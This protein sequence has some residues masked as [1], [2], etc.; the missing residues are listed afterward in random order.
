MTVYT[1]VEN[2][3]KNGI[4]VKDMRQRTG[5]SMTEINKS[6]KLLTARQLITAHHI[7]GDQTKNRR[8]FVLFDVEPGKDASSGP[9]Y[10]GGEF[11]EPFLDFLLDAVLKI[12]AKAV[13]TQ[14][15][16][17]PRDSVSV[18]SVSSSESHERLN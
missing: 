10:Q 14:H 4:W 12:V 8:M 18:L 3:K 16:L 13:R 17:S 2:S 1:L 6:I 9:W 15:P 5:L 7:V 11:D